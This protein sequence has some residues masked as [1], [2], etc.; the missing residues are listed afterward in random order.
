MINFLF[1]SPTLLGIVIGAVI[2]GLFTKAILPLIWK[3]KA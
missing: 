3:P 1:G 2:G